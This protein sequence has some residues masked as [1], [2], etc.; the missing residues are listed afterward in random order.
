MITIVLGDITRE[1]TEAIVNAANSGLRGGGG[2]DGAIHRAAGPSVMR[3]C[4]EIGGC[5]TGGAVV[6]GAGNLAAKK[7][8][9]AVGPVWRGGSRGEAELLASAYAPCF[10]LAR[11]HRL[12]TISFPCIST[13][14]YRYPLEDA[15][16]I[17]LRQGKVSEG[18]F[19]EIRY[20]CFSEQDAR[21]YRRVREE[22]ERGDRR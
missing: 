14:V 9:H 19:D 5:P 12:R 8:I 10:L 1:D 17:A 2:V 11:Q 20:V 3:E 22:I 21:V 15:A 6:T 13:G 7:I 4:R 16:R 18:D